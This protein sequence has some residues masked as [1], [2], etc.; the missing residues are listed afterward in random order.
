MINNQLDSAN[1]VQSRCAKPLE[2]YPERLTA[3]IAAKG[4]SNILSQRCEYLSKLDN[5]CIYFSINLLNL[6]QKCFHFAILRY[7][8]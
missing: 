3:V 8:V 5:V 2:T 1:I 7:C 4:D 6:Q